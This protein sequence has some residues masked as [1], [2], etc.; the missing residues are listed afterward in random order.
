MAAGEVQAMRD[1][2]LTKLRGRHAWLY[3]SRTGDRVDAD[4]LHAGQVQYET[5]V[6]K[7]STTVMMS[8]AWHAQGWQGRHPGFGRES[9]KV[10]A[11]CRS[12]LKLLLK[13]NSLA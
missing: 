7:P 12:H 10:G 8:I 9:H 6:D 1:R 4:R 2:C 3:N 5:A 11:K 13:G